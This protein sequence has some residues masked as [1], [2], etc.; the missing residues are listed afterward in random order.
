MKQDFIKFFKALGAGIVTLFTFLVLV[1][2]AVRATSSQAHSGVIA[3]L[4]VLGVSIF[5]TFKIGELVL[6][7]V[8][9]YFNKEI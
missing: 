4:I 1:G 7:A 2:L 6:A 8:K 3:D 5:G 9:K